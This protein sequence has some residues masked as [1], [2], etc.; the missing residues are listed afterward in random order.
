[1]QRSFKWR[2]CWYGCSKSLVLTQVALAHT[3]QYDP[4][5]FVLG[6]EDGINLNFADWEV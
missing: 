3:H 5:H 2:F 1:M 4:A 6:V